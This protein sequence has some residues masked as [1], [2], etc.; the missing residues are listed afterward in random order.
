VRSV[1][2]GAVKKPRVFPLEYLGSKLPANAVI[3]LIAG[4]GRHNQQAHDPRKA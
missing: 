3:Q 1:K 4:N 2:S